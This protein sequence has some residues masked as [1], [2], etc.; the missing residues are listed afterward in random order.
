MKNK[1]VVRSRISEKQFREIVR[2]FC[3]DIEA[4]KVSQIVG[5]S[6]PSVNK[7]FSALRVK[8]AK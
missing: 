7:L 6:R 2:L 5:V 1:Y 3:I 8:I 4:S